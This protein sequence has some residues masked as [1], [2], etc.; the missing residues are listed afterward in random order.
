MNVKNPKFLNFE[1]VELYKVKINDIQILFKISDIFNFNVKRNR[2]GESSSADMEW[3][4]IHLKNG[5]KTN[6]FC[7]KYLLSQYQCHFRIDID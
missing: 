4:S 6:T 3:P 1:L 5:L 7:P 2:L